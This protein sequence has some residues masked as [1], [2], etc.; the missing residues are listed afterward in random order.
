MIHVLLLNTWQE[1][2]RI[3]WGRSDGK[4]QSV[5]ISELCLS[6][7]RNQGQG[8]ILAPQQGDTQGDILAPESEW[9]MSKI[10]G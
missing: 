9:T 2:L 3:C 10:Q 4:S 7:V 8:A 5:G 1:P 6:A